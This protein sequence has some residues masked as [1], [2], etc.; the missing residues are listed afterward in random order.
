MIEILRDPIWQTVLGIVAII[1]SISAIRF[2]QNIKEITCKILSIAP[3]FDVKDD[4]QGKLKFLFDDK[5]VKTAFLIVFKIMN[6]GKTPVTADDQKRAITVNIPADKILTADI[7]EKNPHDID[8][9]ITTQNCSITLEPT[10]LNPGETITIKTVAESFSGKIT[11]S[12]RIVGANQIET[13]MPNSDLQVRWLKNYKWAITGVIV[14]VIGISSLI[15]ASK[16][17]TSPPEITISR[18]DLTSETAATEKIQINNCASTSA[19]SQEYVKESSAS[20]IALIDNH[21]I[22]NSNGDM[23][24]SDIGTLPIG[25]RIAEAYGLS[26]GQSLGRK[27]QFSIESPA[28]VF[29]VY[30][31]EYQNRYGNG[32]VSIFIPSRNQTIKYSYKIL[33]ESLVLIVSSE[34]LQCP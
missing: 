29:V 1:I 18:G 3:L 6:S 14:G 26:Y 21:E 20:V 23:K 10:L 17:F 31:L 30:T 19:T 22:E 11:T 34:Q 15:L 24:L 7:I 5:P 32:E 13:I 28:A 4:M 9:S 8:A 27:T 33:I 2:Q 16:T 25:Q 12:A